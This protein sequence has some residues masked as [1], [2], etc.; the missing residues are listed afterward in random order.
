VKD[1]HDDIPRLSPDDARLLDSLVQGGFEI[2]AGELSPPERD[3][4]LAIMRLLGLI[5][6]YPVEDAHESL[7]DATLAR[8]D[9]HERERADRMTVTAGGGGAAGRRGR[10]LPRLP[11]FLTVA[12]LI[13]IGTS[14]MLP[15]L[16]Q[17]RRRSIDAHCA[18]NMR[19]LASA[20]EMYASQYDS[21]MPVAGAGLHGSWSRLAHNVINLGPLVDGSFC[22]LEHLNCPGHDG[23]IGESYSYQWQMADARPRWGVG[24]TVMLSDRNPLIDALRAGD[25]APPL[26]MSFNHGGRGQNVLDSAGF[27]RWLEEPMV[28]RRDNIWL[29]EGVDRLEDG[30]RPRGGQDVFL[31]Q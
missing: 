19:Y 8:V 20:F 4:A 22:E 25:S 15:V 13:L 2:D 16:S 24:S 28:G 3:R 10:R 5:D 26:A 18:D 23:D 31:A 14:V 1:R 30:I 9:R 12:A 7:V 29:P 27:V 17:I 21:Q 6:D 11:D